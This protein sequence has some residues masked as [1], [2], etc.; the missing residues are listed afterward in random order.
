MIKTIILHH[1]LDM[2]DLPAAE[3]WFYRYHIPEVL[4]NRP[5][6]YLSYR[7]VPAP[8]GAEDYGA[9]NYKIHENVSMG[10]GETP[11]GLISMTPEVVP[12]RVIMVNVPATPTEDFKGRELSLDDK[13]ILRWVTVFR[14]PEGV[15][16][17]RGDNWYVNVHAP[18]VMRQPG[19]TRFFSY[20]VLP[21]A[22]AVRKGVSR[23]LHPESQISSDWHRVSEQ[24]YENSNGWVESIIKSPPAYSKP[25]WAKHDKYP[26]FEP[27]VDFAG[28]F[29]LERPTDDWLKT[30]PRAY[31]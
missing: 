16:V 7:A 21:S 18:E 8:P 27:G 17:D 5:V 15:S 2:N 3:R 10:E 4:R 24:W 13:T 22:A 31:L 19:L 28:M 9:F 6:S 29:I 20:R 30:V 26:F 12:L 23:F 1:L 11:L 25:S 14:Y